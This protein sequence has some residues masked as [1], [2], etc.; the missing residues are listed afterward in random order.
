MH[1]LLAHNRY[2]T[3]GGE[4]AHIRL[5]ERGLRPFGVDVSLLD[6]VSPRHP[7]RLQRVRLG[8][9]LA[10][11]PAGRRLLDKALTSQEP[12]VVHFHNLTPL[13]TPAAV[14]EAHRFGAAT[15]LTTHN[16]RFACPSG[17]LLRNGRIHE[18]CIEGSSLLCGLRNSRGVWSES[19]AYGLAIEIQR[20]LRMLH[21][22]VDAFIAP[23]NFMAKMLERAGYPAER[24]HVIYHSTPIEPR[25]SEAGSFVFYAGRLSNEKGVQ[26]LLDAAARAPQ[27]PVRIAGEGPLVEL[28]RRAES[29]RLTYLGQLDQAAV[30]K[31]RR[32]ALATIAPS[33]CYEGQPLGVLESMAAGT[34]VIASRLGGLAEIV[35][36]G[37]TGTLVS[38]G[39]ADAFARAMEALW[40]DRPR[41]AA[42][43]KRA[44]EFARERFDPE[45]QLG[46][47]IQLYESLLS[48][49]RDRH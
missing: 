29:D 49:P 16:Y 46:R 21:R 32:E 47:L 8:A 13:L 7:G 2:R 12:D 6:P 42:L 17:T 11:R 25:P 36:D 28:V 43:G 3:P 18:D 24:I 15:V 22:W 19:I 23:S 5:L 39:D 34:P 41:A 40:D 33:E 20:R 1:V 27:V 26:T 30:A 48:A 37:E 10:Y 9:T 4:E 44:W 45:T 35:A 38:A 14:R 31:L